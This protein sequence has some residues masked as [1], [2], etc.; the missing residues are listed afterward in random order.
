MS[1]ISLVWLEFKKTSIKLLK[2]TDKVW[3]IKIAK[4]H[5]LSIFFFRKMGNITM[6]EFAILFISKAFKQ[7]SEKMD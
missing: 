7:L 1:S 2:F 6:K 5:P 4:I 3:T